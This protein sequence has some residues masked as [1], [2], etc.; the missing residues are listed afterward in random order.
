MALTE[1]SK[2]AEVARDA[3]HLLRV[4]LDPTHPKFPREPL[5]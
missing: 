2:L 4:A 3:R 5:R 1:E